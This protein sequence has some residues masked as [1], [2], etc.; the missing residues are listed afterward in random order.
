M[1]AMKER[2]RLESVIE[3]VEEKCEA[4]EEQ[5]GRV[6]GILEEG[7]DEKRSRAKKLWYKFEGRVE[8]WKAGLYLGKDGGKEGCEREE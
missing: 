8:R 1:E 6:D 5:I 7:R 4:L 2:E 3:R